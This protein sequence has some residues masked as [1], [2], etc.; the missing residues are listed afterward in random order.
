MF[1]FFVGARRPDSL[2]TG[3]SNQ[4]YG[5]GALIRGVFRVGKF[6]SVPESP[7]LAPLGIS[8]MKCF[9]SGDRRV[10]EKGRIA[11]SG[12]LETYFR[13]LDDDN[14]LKISRAFYHEVFKRKE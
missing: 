2:Q 5:A 11:E 3:F 8:I 4:E 14:R 13:D 7:G 6:R 10:K 12:L 9:R 1:V